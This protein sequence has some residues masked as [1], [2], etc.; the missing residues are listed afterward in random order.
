M[1]IEKRSF[2]F[3]VL[4]ALPYNL[5]A[6]NDGNKLSDGS[7]SFDKEI[8]YQRSSLYSKGHES[9]LIVRGG[10]SR[11]GATEVVYNT[12]TCE[13]VTS[14]NAI[15]S[16]FSGLMENRGFQKLELGFKLH[17][18]M[19]NSYS[20]IVDF[21]TS[22]DS[23]RLNIKLIDTITSKELKTLLSGISDQSIVTNINISESGT[24]L[25]SNKKFY[26]EY[27]NII[28]TLEANKIN[29]KYVLI[30]NSMLQNDSRL[31]QLLLNKFFTLKVKG[32]KDI[33]YWIESMN[34]FA[35]QAKISSFIPK[36][37]QLPYF[38]KS[39][40]CNSFFTSIE[41]RY[42]LKRI[43]LIGVSNIHSEDSM[44]GIKLHYPNKNIRFIQKPTCSLEKTWNSSVRNCGYI[45][46]G[47]SKLDDYVP[48]VDVHSEYYC[49]G[50]T[51]DIAKIERQ[52]M[53]TERVATELNQGWKFQRTKV[54]YK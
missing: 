52:L 40:T 47:T 17:D 10:D 8:G 14:G 53:G 9:F 27:V 30:L 43:K 6:F 54:I 22:E 33:P 48:C 26:T 13:K 11:Y 41:Y 19:D 38:G 42:I 51:T 7:C 20:N 35:K 50:D 21:T 34:E 12:E 25:L 44:Y 24:K 1:F 28:N 15:K 4:I 36:I 3:F 31:E 39:L 29:Y 37:Q 16:N 18:M 2:L 23:L 49:K 46:W 45:N 5:Y 32:V